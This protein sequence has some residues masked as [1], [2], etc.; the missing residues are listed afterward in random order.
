MKKVLTSISCSETETQEDSE[1]KRLERNKYFP[2]LLT[3]VESIH[4]TTE[5]ENFQH[6]KIDIQNVLDSK[7]EELKKVFTKEVNDLKRVI[8]R[9][10]MNCIREED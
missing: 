8:K 4:Q 6:S 2:L 1:R 9:S 5:R 7:I 10:G 3:L